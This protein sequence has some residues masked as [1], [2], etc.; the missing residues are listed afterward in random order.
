MAVKTIKLGGSASNV[1][2]AKVAHGLMLMTWKPTPVPDEQCFEAIIAGIDQLPPG[3]KMF[4]NSGE[5]YGHNLST[6]NLELL[7]RFFAKYP[8]YADKVF[9]SVK[10]GMKAHTLVPD[11]SPEN[12]RRSVDY[13]IEKLGPNKKVD[14]FQCARV[15]SEPPVEDVMKTLLE[16]VKEGKFDHIGL[17]ECS[18]ETVKR[19]NSV[20]PVAVVEIEISPWSYEEE[21]RKVISTCK[22]LGIAIAAYSPLGHGFLTG[23]LNPKD[24]EEGDI[25]GHGIR[26]KEENW[27]HNVK[28]V[29]TLSS[30]ASKKGVTP[31]QL[32]IAWVGVLGPHIMPLPGSSSP[33]RKLE[34]LAGGDIELSEAEVKEIADVVQRVGVQ[35]TRGADVPDIRALRMWG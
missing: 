19:A 21:T 31:A 16:L 20:A 13:I 11:A 17:S 18:A 1:E 28:V 26:T 2:V 24:L 8:E 22:E 7:S 9:L 25:R 32:C 34:N 6:A 10:G 33:A 27:K 4:I 3:A 23:K 14:L 12:L 30:I 5:F 35:G 15:A 29:E